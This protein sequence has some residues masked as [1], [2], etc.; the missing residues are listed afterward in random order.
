MVS[1]PG[2]GPITPGSCSLK[3]KEKDVT[4]KLLCFSFCFSFVFILILYFVY[5]V[6]SNN[7]STMKIEDTRRS[8][9]RDYTTHGA[10]DVTS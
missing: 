5:D 2:Q 7:N 6:D 9:D 8:E 3:G 1:Q 4:K 10:A